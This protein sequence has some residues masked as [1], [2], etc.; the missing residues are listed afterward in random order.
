VVGLGRAAGEPVDLLAVFQRRLDDLVFHV[1]DV[2]HVGYVLGAV[3]VAQEPEQ[4]VED[5]G[6]PGVADVGIV[7]DRGPADVEPHVVFVDRFEALLLARKGVVDLDRHDASQKHG[8]APPGRTPPGQGRESGSKDSGAG[9]R[10]VLSH[11]GDSTV[12]FW[13]LRRRA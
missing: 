4:D 7:V 12:F 2:A 13:S 5:H 10:P 6:G 3:E 11:V 8:F 9:P 1:G